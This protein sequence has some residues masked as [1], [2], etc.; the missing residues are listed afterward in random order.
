MPGGRGRG[1][2][3]AKNNFYYTYH[4]FNGMKPLP[5]QTPTEELFWGGVNGS[6]ITRAEA[7]HRIFSRPKAHD[8]DSAITVTSQSSDNATDENRSYDD[9]LDWME[10]VAEEE[11]RKQRIA[12]Q[13][14]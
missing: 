5:L 13:K 4:I 11:K 3:V 9:V 14:W 12:Q 8:R 7:M 1:T 10:C 6:P 2:P